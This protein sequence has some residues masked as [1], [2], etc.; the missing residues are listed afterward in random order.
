MSLQ[1]YCK[2]HCNHCNMTQNTQ[3]LQGFLCCSN[4]ST[5]PLQ[6]PYFFLSL[7]AVVRSR[8]IKHL[9]SFLGSL[10]SYCNSLHCTTA[11]QGGY[12]KYPPLTVAVAEWFPLQ[13]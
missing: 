10:Q 1:S 9:A 13:H 4:F 6:R 3:C 5:K 11:L 2:S 12:I 7:I 8:K